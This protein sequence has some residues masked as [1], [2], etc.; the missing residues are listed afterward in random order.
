MT[1]CALGID[2]GSA[3]TK[4]VVIGATTTML[5]HHI[6]ATDPRIDEQSGRLVDLARTAT[7]LGQAAPI[8]STGYGRKLVAAATG[9]LTE[10]T[11]HARG[12]YACFGHAG[13][14]ID[15]GGQDSKVITLGP[16]GKVGRFQMNDKCS[17]G[18]G[19]FLEVVAAR[20]GLSLGRLSEIAL[21][22]PSEAAISSTCTVFAE[23]EIVS[24]IAR[25]EPIAAIARGLYRA[26]SRRVAALARSIG[27]APP[28][29]LSGGVALSPAMKALL[30][31]ELAVALEAPAE[32]QL[33][34]AYGAALLGL[35]PGGRLGAEPRAPEQW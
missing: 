16:G 21:G 33:L 18:T 32:P 13:T 7:G 34:G 27:P 31:E 23:T 20:L 22:A 29:M 11:C 14:L 3:T 26:L 1:G 25:G 12:A 6:E 17:A 15:L 35:E 30:A 19:R 9:R 2:V 5:W 8:V 28:F 4:L 10:I 24:R